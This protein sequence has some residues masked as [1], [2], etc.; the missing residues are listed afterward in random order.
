MKEIRD[1]SVGE[2]HNHYQKVRVAQKT[3]YDC[4]NRERFQGK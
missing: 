1:M 3:S 4:E 2:R